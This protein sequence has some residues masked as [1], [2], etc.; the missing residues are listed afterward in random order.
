MVGEVDPYGGIDSTPWVLTFAAKPVVYSL[1]HIRT[2]RERPPHPP[3]DIRISESEMDD[4]IAY[5]QS[6]GAD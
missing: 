3:Q 5:L 4:L 2:F 6:L 1:E